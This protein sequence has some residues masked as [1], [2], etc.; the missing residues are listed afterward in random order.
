V[1]DT[2]APEIRELTATPNSLWPPNHKMVKVKVGV[3]AVDG[4]GS[5]T[6]KILSVTSNDTGNTSD[7]KLAG[8][9]G[10]NLRAARMA[11]AAGASRG[12]RI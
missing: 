7:W 12:S 8:A 3:A 9:L 4:C 11:V 1:Q 5:V 10:L 2:T 6:S